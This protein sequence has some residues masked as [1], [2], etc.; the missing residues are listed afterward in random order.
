MLFTAAPPFLP[1]GHSLSHIT[2]VT[3]DNNSSL[4]VSMNVFPLLCLAILSICCPS[5]SEWTSIRGLVPCSPSLII[6]LEDIETAQYLFEHP[7]ASSPVVAFSSLPEDNRI[8]KVTTAHLRVKARP[9][10]YLRPLGAFYALNGRHVP[11]L[12]LA[13][14]TTLLA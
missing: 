2:S 1:T 12:H 10:R 7:G 3:L 6:Q 4:L 14:P 11:I 13:R 9:R 8:P 5:Q